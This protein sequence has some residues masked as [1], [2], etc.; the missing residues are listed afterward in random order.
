MS[1]FL[2]M[3]AKNLHSL[4]MIVSKPILDMVSQKYPPKSIYPITH[5]DLWKYTSHITK[6]KYV[7]DIVHSVEVKKF[8]YHSVFT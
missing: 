4:L 1:E 6:H 2:A 8:F 7:S 5:V 3:N